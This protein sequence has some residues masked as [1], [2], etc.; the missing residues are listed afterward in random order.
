MLLNE[1]IAA[2]KAGYKG[3]DASIFGRLEYWAEAV[4]EIEVMPT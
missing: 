1:L 2:F 4:G 3:R